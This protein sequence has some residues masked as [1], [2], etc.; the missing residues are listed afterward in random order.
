M[1]VAPDNQRHLHRRVF[2]RLGSVQA[3]KPAT[4]DHHAVVSSAAAH[5]APGISRNPF[6]MIC[7]ISVAEKPM[8][9]TL[10][11]SSDTPAPNNVKS[12]EF[13]VIV[14]PCANN[15]RAG[16]CSRVPQIANARLLAGQ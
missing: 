2:E 12:F 8:R 6:S 9:V 13:T 11:S 7:S 4:D 15:W 16:C 5:Q 3:A 10:N 1:K 14:T